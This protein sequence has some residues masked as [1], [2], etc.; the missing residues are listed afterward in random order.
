MPM[1]PPVMLPPDCCCCM[2]GGGA[3]AAAGRG[4]GARGRG[5]AREGTRGGRGGTRQRNESRRARSRAR[6]KRTGRARART[7]P[8]ATTTTTT[9]THAVR[10]S[11]WLPSACASKSARYATRAGQIPSTWRVSAIDDADRA[12]RGFEHHHHQLEEYYHGLLRCRL[13]LSLRSRPTHRPYLSRLLSLAGSSSRRVRRT[14]RTTGL[15]PRGSA[16][17]SPPPPALVE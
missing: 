17:V 8:P 15:R 1:S 16:L 2:A 3:P 4:G 5:A 13:C 6:R 11:G 9:T 12:I 14:R 7:R 10:V